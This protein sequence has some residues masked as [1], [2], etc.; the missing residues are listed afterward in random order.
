MDFTYSYLFEWIGLPL[1]IFI[2]RISDVSIGTLRIMLFSKSKKW[3]APMLGFLEIMIWLVAIRQIFNNLNNPLCYIAYAGGF[4][5][6]N[7]VGIWIEHRLALGMQ[8]LRIITGKDATQL[9]EN[10]KASGYGVTSMDAEGANGKVKI[11]FSLIK[12]KDLEQIKDVIRQF[13]PRAFFSIE[14]VR[15]V[16]EGIFPEG[17]GNSL[18]TISKL[19]KFEKKG[20]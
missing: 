11:I 12:R 18:S 9:V 13:N 20:K 8:V 1:I 3:V 19:L 15:F 7:Y 10:L 4:A 5:T 14:D 17:N 2:A 16:T 6:G